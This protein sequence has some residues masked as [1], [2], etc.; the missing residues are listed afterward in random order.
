MRTKQL[1]ISEGT[2]ELKFRGFAGPVAYRIEGEPQKLKLGPAR[3]RGS[4]STTAEIAEDA[5][6]AGDGA[7]VL[8]DGDSYRITMLGHSTGA[9]E[10]FV[11][12]R[13]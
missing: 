1:P 3:V 7:L 2:G 9:T 4:I 5:F 13:Y 6:R 8:E 12:L 11:E 10:V